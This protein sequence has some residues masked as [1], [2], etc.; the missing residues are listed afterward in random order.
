MND[1]F[2]FFTV[3]LESQ[4][5]RGSPKG[6]L[7]DRWLPKGQEDA[8]RLDTGDANATLTM[9]FERF[10][11][12][13]EG[14]L[15]FDIRQ[16]L[17]GHEE[18]ISVQPNPSG[19]LF[20]LLQIHNVPEEALA[21]MREHRTNDPAYMELGKSV[22]DLLRPVSRLLD[23]LRT[24]FGQ[25]WLPLLKSWDSRDWSLA[26][27]FDQCFSLKWSED[28]SADLQSWN[29]FE[30]DDWR[31]VGGRSIYRTA[32]TQEDWS[33]AKEVLSGTYTPSPAAQVLARA[34]VLL[35]E[36]EDRYALLEAVTALELAVTELLNKW[37]SDRRAKRHAE[38]VTKLALAARLIAVTAA[39]DGI[40]RKELELALEAIDLRNRVAHGAWE[41]NRWIHPELIALFR[42]TAA[43][44]RAPVLKTPAILPTGPGELARVSIT[45]GKP[46]AHE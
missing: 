10:G 6:I 30:P 27:Y 11:F 35:D 16:K 8:F 46:R 3:R 41:L 32:L 26:G 13:R 9:W 44:I 2:L 37:S 40:P 21:A 33:L 39:M 5:L 24:S 31:V 17:S 18:L 1:L 23:V 14:R 4:E 42:V 36:G 29:A 34:R 25:F 20:G 15:Y 43:L 45:F 28:P 38:Q 19:P 7:F 22:L 12:V